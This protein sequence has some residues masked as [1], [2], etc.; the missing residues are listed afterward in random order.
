VTQPRPRRNTR[1][2][3]IVVG[4][5]LAVCCALAIGLGVF[6]VRTF[7]NT[8]GPA[9]AATEAFLVDWRDG[10]TAAAYEKLCAS[11]RERTTQEQLATTMTA[12]RPTS[13]EITRVD[14]QTVNG[15]LGAAVTADLTFA[16]GLTEP[17]TFRLRREGDAWKIC[18]N[19]Y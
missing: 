2:V 8:A 10:N 5:V 11:V 14:V 12:R 4:S 16:G 15:Q 9:R 18:G 1:T 17:R 6:A 13:Y 3:L 7:N 19:P